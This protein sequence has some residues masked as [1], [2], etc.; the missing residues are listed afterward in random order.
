MAKLFAR[1][2]EAGPVRGRFWFEEDQVYGFVRDVEFVRDFG[3]ENGVV[4]FELDGWLGWM[5]LDGGR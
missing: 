2:E 3:G 4:E 5:P 1:G